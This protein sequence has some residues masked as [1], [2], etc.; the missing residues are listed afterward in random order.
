[1][2]PAPGQASRADGQA[3]CKDVTDAKHVSVQGAQKVAVQGASLQQHAGGAGPTR[4]VGAD[5]GLQAGVEQ[6]AAHPDIVPRRKFRAVG[7]QAQPK[8][9]VEGRRCEQVVRLIGPKH[10]RPSATRRRLANAGQ[11]LEA[12]LDWKKLQRR[13]AHLERPGVHRDPQGQEL[14]QHRGAHVDFGRFDRNIARGQGD[15]LRA[16]PRGVGR[17]VDDQGPACLADAA[18]DAALCGRDINIKLK[19]ATQ[20]ANGKERILRRSIGRHS[21]AQG[22]VVQLHEQQE[23]CRRVRGWK[24]RTLCR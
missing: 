13:D 7:L 21:V 3:R 2:D 10:R 22:Q 6:I 9:H 24:P 4:V 17:K 14:S 1:M 20:L 12:S 15:R 18:G 23:Q 19:E 16:D 11:T 8:R 5:I